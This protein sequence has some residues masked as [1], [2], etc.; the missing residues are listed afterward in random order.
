[1]RNTY[2]AAACAVA[3]CSTGVN[4]AGPFDAYK[5]KMKDGMYE[6]KT[7]MEMPGMPGGMGKTA[8]TMQHCIT[9]QD[10]ESGKMGGGK[11]QMPKDC[12]VKDFKMSGNN[13]T[14]KLI[15]KGQMNMQADVNMS[16][17]DSGFKMDQKMSMNQGG[18]PMQMNHRMESRYIGPCKK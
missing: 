7:E 15:C 11:D 17:N 14:Y 9:P 4:A 16:F 6:I 3:L 18:Q 13:A 12:E 2:L 10:I 1:M 5:G 8:H